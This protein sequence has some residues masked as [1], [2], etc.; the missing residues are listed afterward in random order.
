MGTARRV[1]VVEDRS[2][3]RRVPVGMLRDI[4]AVDI[5][6]AGDGTLAL[7]AF[8]RTDPAIDLMNYDL[9][10][11]RW[12]ASSSSATAPSIAGAPPSSCP[13]ARTTDERGRPTVADAETNRPSE[14]ARHGAVL[15]RPSS[16]T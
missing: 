8:E 9:D 11:P 16:L 15:R 6:A 4:G 12:T 7:E 2:L 3:Q 1:L 10:M 13:P 14:V 5:V